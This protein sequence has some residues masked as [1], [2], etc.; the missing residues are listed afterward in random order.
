M[1]PR[2][3]LPWDLYAQEAGL[4]GRAVGTSLLRIEPFG[5]QRRAALESGGVSCQPPVTGVII[6]ATR[7]YSF[8]P[9]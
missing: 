1:V 7:C 8:T 5:E 6:V 3:P 2:P 9:R 4:A